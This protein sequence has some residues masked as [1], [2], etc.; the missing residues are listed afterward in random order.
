MDYHFETIY[1]RS[2][3]DMAVPVQVCQPGTYDELNRKHLPPGKKVD[4]YLSLAF[5]GL[6]EI[7]FA[8]KINH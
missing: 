3:V 2:V 4:L 7:P 1:H 6:K 5:L 8:S